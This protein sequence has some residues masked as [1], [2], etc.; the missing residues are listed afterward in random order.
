M[1]KTRAESRENN[2]RALLDAAFQVVTR[3]GYRAKLED[4]AERAGLT[5]GAV[6]SLFGS[7]NGLVVAL[8]TDYLQPHYA[9]FEEAVPAELD[10]VAAVDAF[11]R[12]Y[13]RTCD[14]PEALSALSLQM[15]LQE[16]SLHDPKLGAQLAESVR[17][18]ENHLIALFTGRDH[19]GSVVTRHQAE[20]LTTALR[21]LLVGLSQGVV[22]G[23]AAG[24]DEQYF[25]DV[26]CAL[27]S[28]ASL[29]G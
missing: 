23:L 8:V 18:Q 27:V 22:L 2:R 5:T 13:R 11:A 26:A 7:K 6:Y 20:R 29:V 25:A 24:A 1:R 19:N 3:D 12:H 21:A 15:T 10:L 28:D 14:A 16:M 4:I 17:E 9:Q